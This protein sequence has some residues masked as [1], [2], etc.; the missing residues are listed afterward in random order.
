M[1]QVHCTTTALLLWAWFLVQ[2]ML[3]CGTLAFGVEPGPATRPTTQPGGIRLTLEAEEKDGAIVELLNGS[4]KP[5]VIDQELVYC[6]SIE[7]FA[8]DGTRVIL[9]YVRGT[10]KRDPPERG[11]FV[12]LDAG[13]SVRRH[14]KLKEGFPLFVTGAATQ[15]V[16]GQLIDRP[17]AFEAAYRVPAGSQVATLRI[18]YARPRD[19]DFMKAFEQYTGVSFQSLG[20]F[21]GPLR[22]EITLSNGKEPAR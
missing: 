14:V 16:G 22:A 12:K 2:L 1:R 3:G 20:L 7:A 11:R 17:I 6:L 13:Q 4:A 9:E 10:A 15:A 8:A 21:E 5:I 19:R 18:K